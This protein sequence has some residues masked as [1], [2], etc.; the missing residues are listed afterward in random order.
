MTIDL[1]KRTISTG[2][3]YRLINATDKDELLT[4]IG[5]DLS[6]IEFKELTRLFSL[7]LSEAILDCT[8]LY[9]AEISNCQFVNASLKEINLYQS[10]LADVNFTNTDLSRSN[11]MGSVL[12]K[13]LLRNTNFTNANLEAIDFNGIGFWNQEK[14]IIENIN[15]NEAILRKANLRGYNPQNPKQYIDFSTRKRSIFSNRRCFYGKC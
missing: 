14:S 13:C 12:K 6:K 3:F 15:F 9:K 5:T 1:T 7:N 4:L 2:E 10:I 8:D 11:L